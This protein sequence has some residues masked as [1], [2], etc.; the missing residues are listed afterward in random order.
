MIRHFT[1]YRQAM[2]NIGTQDKRLITALAGRSR[3]ELKQVMHS[4]VV[5]LCVFAFRRESKLANMSP[6]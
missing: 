4:Y 1:Y 6:S 2:E 5:A 3:K